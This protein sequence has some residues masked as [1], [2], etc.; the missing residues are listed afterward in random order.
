MRLSKTM[1]VAEFENGYWYATQIKAF[2]RAIGIPHSSIL[3]KDELQ[4]S[5][6]RFLETGTVS[7]PTKRSLAKPG[8]KDVDRGLRLDLPVV[9]YTND[10]E[11]KAFLAREAEKIAPGVKR[12]S[13][14]RYRLNRW[15]EE[16]LA[17]G[18]RITYRDLVHQY[19][20]LNQADKPFA[21]IPI[22]CYVNFLS[23]FSK[24]E[25][26]TTRADALAAWKQLKR[27]NAPKTYQAWK[28][29]TRKATGP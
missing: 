11:T 24:A 18:R 15:R 26:H 9:H 4:V 29:A 28:A 17:G 14:A 20:K 7:L 13:G 16:Q 2:A 10:K 3:R 19:V 8:V 25:K 23:D 21:Q 27:M 12:R 22:V 6:K 1:T 5:I